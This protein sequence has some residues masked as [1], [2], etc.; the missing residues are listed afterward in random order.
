MQFLGN[1]HALAVTIKHEK[2][3]A[4]ITEY[5]EKK[6]KKRGTTS[7]LCHFLYEKMYKSALQLFILLLK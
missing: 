4:E 3:T 2:F 1:S 5:A 7:F 6:I